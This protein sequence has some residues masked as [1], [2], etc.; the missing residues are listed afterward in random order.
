[1][2]GVGVGPGDNSKINNRQKFIFSLLKFSLRLYFSFGMDGLGRKLSV[3]YNCM[4]H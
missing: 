1:M 3:G 2:S 4:V